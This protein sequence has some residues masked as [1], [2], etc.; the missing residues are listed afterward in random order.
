ML[1]SIDGGQRWDHALPPP[2]HIV[3]ASP[4]PYK[5]PVS[6]PLFGFRS[7]SNILQSRN[8]NGTPSLSAACIC[9]SKWTLLAHAHLDPDKE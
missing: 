3:A 6:T 8:S 1:K 4:Y 5:D 2:H 9:C 7:P